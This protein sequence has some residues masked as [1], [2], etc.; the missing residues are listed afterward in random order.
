M[1]APNYNGRTVWLP[2]LNRLRAGDILLT[3]SVY[4]DE[5]GGTKQAKLI[6]AVSGGP[7]EHAA[8]CIAPPT[9][10]EAGGG[11]EGGVFTLSMSRCFA[12][13]L[14]N[15][16]VLRWPDEETALK[17]AQFCQL[18][19]GRSYSTIKAIASIVPLD[20]L[21]TDRGVFCSSLVAHAYKLADPIAFEQLRPDKISPVGLSKLEGFRDV[22]DELFHAGPAPRNV[23]TM[24][25]LD[26]KSAPSPADMQTFITKDYAKA[27]IP[28]SDQ[29]V[30]AFPEAELERPETFYGFLA[31]LPLAYDAIVKVAQERHQDYSDALFALDDRA[32]DVLEDRRLSSNM[33]RIIEIDRTELRRTIAESHKSD[34]DIDLQHI[35]GLVRARRET[36]VKRHAAAASFAKYEKD[37]D[38]IRLWN[39]LQNTVTRE[40]EQA[41]VEHQRILERCRPS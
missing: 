24:N 28:W 8:I 9:F 37:F 29:F 2:H 30:E 34:P 21:K 41:M 39:A 14:Q 26:G 25:A 12:H 7:F 33:N 31:F 5:A 23:E 40:I 38:S 27:L 17:A 13:D 32:A 22:T 3:R 1:P 4:D 16:C 19:V 6:R 36:L 18:Q 15:V 11:D 20:I 35:S 10:A